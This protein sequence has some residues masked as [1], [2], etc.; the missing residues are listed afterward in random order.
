MKILSI[1]T[2]TETTKLEIIID[3]QVV[4]QIA[5]ES[6]RNLGSELLPKI[7]QLLKQNKIVLSNLNAIVVNPGPGS[8]T[9]TRIGVATA[10]SLAFAL[11][12]PV[13]TSANVNHGHFSS[14]VAPV[15]SSEPS[16]TIKESNHSN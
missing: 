16:V 2:T 6:G 15:Y 9:G 1:D 3:K 4:D 13:S 12:I 11:D 8:F 14:P 7:D 10:N 5:W